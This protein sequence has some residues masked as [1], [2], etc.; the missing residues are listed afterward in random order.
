M[1]PLGER[2]PIGERLAD[3][4]HHGVLLVEVHLGPGRG[5]PVAV[6]HAVGFAERLDQGGGERAAFVASQPGFDVGSRPVV[7]VAE[8]LTLPAA[9]SRASNKDSA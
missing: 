1:R 4:A 6:A 7:P 2:P 9:A 8:T 3:L 5:E